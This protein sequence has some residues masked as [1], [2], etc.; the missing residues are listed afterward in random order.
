MN[1]ESTTLLVL[2]LV[3]FLFMSGTL[4][5]GTA[6]N[7]R[8][9]VPPPPGIPNSQLGSAGITAGTQLATGNFVGAAQTT[10][11]V[12]E[13]P[14]VRAATG[15]AA[16]GVFNFAASSVTQPAASVARSVVS[17]LK[18]LNPF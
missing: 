5:G 2:V 9:Q 18:S 11:K 6:F 16:V 3:V 17:G 1:G 15:R 13:N 7:Q 8:P 4:G 14:K 10:A 12:F